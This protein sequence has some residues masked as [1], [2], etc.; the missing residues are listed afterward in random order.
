[1]ATIVVHGTARRNVQP[2]FV[3]VG[4]GLTHLAKDAPTALDTVAVRSQQLAEI[5]AALGLAPGDGVTEG[6]TVAEEV[7]WRH[8]QQVSV[9]YRAT[10]GVAATVRST[11][12]VGALLRDAVGTCQASVRSLDWQVDADNPARRALLGDAATDARARAQ[13]Y[14]AA[15]GVELGNVEVISEQ[16]LQPTDA[17]VGGGETG[18]VYS[19]RSMKMADAAVSVSGGQIELSADVYVRFAART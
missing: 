3:V 10:T 14:A 12:L 5:L 9:G 6:V 17:S 8:D 16:P 11:G 18:V 2:D 19:A 13:A 1:M 15:L 4:L 7:E